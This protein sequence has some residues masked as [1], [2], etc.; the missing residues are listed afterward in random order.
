MAEPTSSGGGAGGA[1][2]KSALKIRDD[3]D[4]VAPSS[5]RPA[6]PVTF[7]S[8]LARAYSLK[9]NW[10]ALFNAPPSRATA[11]DGMRGI[12]FMW[13]VMTHTALL[14]C[15]FL[16]REQVITLSAGTSSRTS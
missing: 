4:P 14:R 5:A 10:H 11:L 12:A 16:S 7:L 8:K 13:V 2:G 3:P 1:V 15:F 9:R 6:P